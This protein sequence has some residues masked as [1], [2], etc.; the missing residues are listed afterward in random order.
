MQKG[1]DKVGTGNS[2][3]KREPG[4]RPEAVQTLVRERRRYVR[5]AQKR[6]LRKAE[7]EAQEKV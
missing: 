3:R 6:A 1:G 5:I 7:R 2:Q 4:E